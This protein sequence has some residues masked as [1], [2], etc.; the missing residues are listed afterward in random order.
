MNETDY[1]KAKRVIVT[2]ISRSIAKD[3]SI[4]K[5]EP[6]KISK[7]V[8]ERYSNATNGT[9]KLFQYSSSTAT[10][11]KPYTYQ[12]MIPISLF[13]K[14]DECLSM[15]VLSETEGDDLDSFLNEPFNPMTDLKCGG[16]GNSDDKC[17][18][19]DEE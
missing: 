19:K 16:C 12:N 14:I 17:Y 10:N 2:T 3:G 9:L 18:C 1:E 11:N 15:V 4:M 6:S 7:I 5:C 8:F 13:N